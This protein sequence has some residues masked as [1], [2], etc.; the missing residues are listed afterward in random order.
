MFLSFLVLVTGQFIFFYLPFDPKPVAIAVTFVTQPFQFNFT[1]TALSWQAIFRL[2]S[3]S[4]SFFCVIIYIPFHPF[5]V[6][7]EQ[8]NVK[9]DI[10]WV[11]ESHY[12]ASHLLYI[13]RVLAH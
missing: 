8:E 7:S 9:S 5:C 13:R 4:S 2:H 12:T 10:L 11:Q 1:T 6:S 3:A